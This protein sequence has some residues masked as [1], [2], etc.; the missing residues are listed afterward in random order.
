MEGRKGSS[1]GRAKAKKATGC[2]FEVSVLGY[3]AVCEALEEGQGQEL[4]LLISLL[5]SSEAAALWLV[6]EGPGSH[7]AGGAPTLNPTHSM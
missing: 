3:G 5:E 6:R 4:R 2:M 1:G 7:S